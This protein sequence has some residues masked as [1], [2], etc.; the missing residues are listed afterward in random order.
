MDDDDERDSTLGDWYTLE[1]PPPSAPLPSCTARF[2]I[3]RLPNGAS[4]DRA[5]L[6]V[7]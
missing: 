4:L 1:R 3:A 5:R 6:G 2:L 7:P